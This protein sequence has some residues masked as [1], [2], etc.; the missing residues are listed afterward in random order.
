M[1]NLK[2][3]RLVFRKFKDE[4]LEPLTA[5]VTDADSMKFTGFKKSQS[6][7]RIQELLRKWQLEGEGELGVWAVECARSGDFVGWSML[8]RTTS[9]ASELGYMISVD[10]RRRGYATEIASA[11]LDYALSTLKLSRVTAT[12]SSKNIPS[13]K[14]LEKAGMRRVVEQAR[15]EGVVCYEYRVGE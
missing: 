9:E 2:T 3:S 12:T 14:V 1:I 5:L 4:D 10:Q 11:L 13:V 8:K 15:D 7:E 6:I